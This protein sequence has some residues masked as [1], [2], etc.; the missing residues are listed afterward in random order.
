MS[1][2]NGLKTSSGTQWVKS[3]VIE[4]PDLTDSQ[5]SQE[6]EKRVDR[7]EIQKF[8]SKK[9]NLLFSLSWKSDASTSSE[10]HD[11]NYNHYV[12]MPPLKQF[13]ES[14]NMDQK[15]LFF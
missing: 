7:V 2:E 14:P 3:L 6:K 15:E 9:V 8:I 13:M 10:V 11:D 4:C 1:R 12:V 5:D